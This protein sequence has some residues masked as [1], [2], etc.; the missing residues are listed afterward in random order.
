MKR[1]AYSLSLYSKKKSPAIGSALFD[2][3]SNSPRIHYQK[4]VAMTNVAIS[5]LGDY[6]VQS[7]GE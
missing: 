7:D 5:F 6:T 4:H 2:I 1:A 3:L